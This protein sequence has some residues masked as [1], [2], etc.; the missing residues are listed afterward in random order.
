MIMNRSIKAGFI[1]VQA[2][3]TRTWSDAEIEKVLEKFLKIWAG[4]VD[5]ELDQLDIT[6]ASSAIAASLQPGSS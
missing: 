1:L 6:V 3:G 5:G 2:D 4:T